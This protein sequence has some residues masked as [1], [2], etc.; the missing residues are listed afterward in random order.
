M[1]EPGRFGPALHDVIGLPRLLCVGDVQG[2]WSAL[3]ELLVEAGFLSADSELRW[4]AGT[5]GLLLI[6]DLT[7]GGTQPGEVLEALPRLEA[8]AVAAGG[9]LVLLRGNHETMLFAALGFED[10][11]EPHALPRWFAN[12]G[13]DTLARLAA[14]R[15]ASVSDRL[16]ARVMAP[17]A[18]SLADIEAEAR[19]LIAWVREAWSAELGFVRSRIRSAAVVN[20]AVLAFHAAPNWRAADLGS[21]VTCPDDELVVAWDRTWLQDWRHGDPSGFAAAL[22]AL[23][24]RLDLPEQGVRLR[25]FVFGHTALPEFEVPGFRGRQY[26]IARLVT[27]DPASG[28]PGLYDLMTVPRE[29]PVGGALGGLEFGPEGVVAVYGRELA[30]PDRTWP[31]RELLG[32]PDPAFG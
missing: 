31:R 16:L 24:Q 17:L 19:A 15:G 8:Q 27:P 18:G 3:R 32:A 5:A 29:V 28:T 2:N 30:S 6:G 13:L 9:R 26:R 23:K 22:A 1:A 10:P 12:G 7:D 4:S 14:R 21:F 11:A 20:G 25:H